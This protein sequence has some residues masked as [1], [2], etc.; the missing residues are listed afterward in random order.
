[1]T[2]WETFEFAVQI[3][4]NLAPNLVANPKMAMYYISEAEQELQDE[5]GFVML[6]RFIDLDS[7]SA[8][9]AYD[10]P[11]DVRT[12]DTISWT[13][14]EDSVTRL[15]VD[16][17]SPDLW[18]GVAQ[19]A[20]SDRVPLAPM[21]S[22]GGACYVKIEFNKLVVFPTTTG[23]KL[24]IRYKPYRG[25]YSPS[26]TAEWENYGTNPEPMMMANG[27]PRELQAAAPGVVSYLAANLLKDEPRGVDRYASQ[28]QFELNKWTRSKAKVRLPQLENTH[29]HGARPRPGGGVA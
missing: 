8:T 25:T 13:D 23:G 18:N 14:A 21:S 26:N 4:R 5:G 9:G 6:E 28:M 3:T 15:P 20:T 16:L 22:A 27:L 19:V 12:I 10:L 7:G 17:M 11:P 2:Y 24:R 29:R 1:M